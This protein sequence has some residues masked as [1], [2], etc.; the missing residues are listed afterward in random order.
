M[1][2]GRGVIFLQR[3]SSARQM[4]IVLLVEPGFLADAPAEV[5]GLE[6]AATRRAESPQARKHLSLKRVAF[7][8][9]VA[10]RGA[11]KDSEGS[12]L[13]LIALDCMFAGRSGLPACVAQRLKPR[14]TKARSR[15][16]PTGERPPPSPLHLGGG[17]G[18]AVPA[19]IPSPRRS[20][21]RAGRFGRIRGRV[22]E[23]RRGC[24]RR[25]IPMRIVECGLRNGERGLCPGTR[26]SGG[27]ACG[28]RA[29]RAW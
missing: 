22:R 24:R 15:P 5:N 18:R 2:L 23:V 11:Y 13:C 16:A 17:T 27:A 28:L 25:G 14:T 9:Q 10:E 7:S 4:F 19:R 1:K 21:S 20:I 29:C 26:G 6:R 3:S 8:L 12:P